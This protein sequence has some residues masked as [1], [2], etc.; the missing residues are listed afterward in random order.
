M[1]AE[2]CSPSEKARVHRRPWR[3]R[4]PRHR[5]LLRTARDVAEYMAARDPAYRPGETANPFNSLKRYRHARKLLENRSQL[6]SSCVELPWSAGALPLPDAPARATCLSLPASPVCGRRRVP[7]PPTLVVTEQPA[8]LRRLGSCES[9][10]FSV[11]EAERMGSASD[12]SPASFRSEYSQEELVARMP[13]LVKRSSSVYTDSSD[14]VS[15]LGLDPDELRERR[16]PVADHYE[17]DIR[18]IVEYFERSGGGGARGSRALRQ[19][20]GCRQRALDRLSLERARQRLERAERAQV[21]E[22]LVADCRRL[23]DRRGDPCGGAR[24][25]PKPKVPI[26]EGTVRDKLTVFERKC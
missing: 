11:G 13:L 7:S 2:T 8:T 12:L 6:F 14:D 17:K 9:G 25:R 18:Q 26:S 22:R 10:F 15:S 1:L 5:P 21:P 23:F 19:S 24:G 3:R 20:L 16:R 4:E